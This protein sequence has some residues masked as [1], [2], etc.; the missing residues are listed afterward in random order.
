VNL[1]ALKMAEVRR[2]KIAEAQQAMHQILNRR[3]E[4]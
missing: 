4:L 1:E 3:E 2:R